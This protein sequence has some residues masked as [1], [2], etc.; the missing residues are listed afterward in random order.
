[1]PAI[2]T[3]AALIRTIFESKA[4]AEYENHGVQTLNYQEMPK[5]AFGIYISHD[6]HYGP[7]VLIGLKYLM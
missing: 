1:M 6:L 2:N 5:I 7:H 3:K 4:F